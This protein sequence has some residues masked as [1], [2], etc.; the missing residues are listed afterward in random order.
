MEGGSKVRDQGRAL[1]VQPVFHEV[2][3]HRH[4]GRA[5]ERVRRVR[6]AVEKLD[7][8]FRGRVRDRVVNGSLSK[9]RPG[10]HDSPRQSLSR[11]HQ[12]WR[13]V[14]VFRSKRFAKAAEPSDHFVEN[15][16]NVVLV[17]DAADLLQVPF[18]R[19][20]HTRAPRHR[21]YNDGCNVVCPVQRHDVVEVVC[22]VRAPLWLPSGE[23]RVFEGVRVAQV[24][25]SGQERGTESS[26]VGCDPTYRNPSKPYPVV[27]SFAP[28]KARPLPLSL[29]S[30]VRERHL[31]RRVHACASTHGEE[32]LAEPALLQVAV[33]GQGFPPLE[34][35]FVSNLKSWGI[36]HRIHLFL[37]SIDHRL[38]VHA[39]STAP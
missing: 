35:Q 38:W 25:N 30:V 9:D 4:P 12:V 8:V 37:D 36:R 15:E 31:Q 21:L 24:V 11:G 33:V 3:Q 16:E 22:E 29:A 26:P 32:G 19:H 7:A 2:L 1:L 10:R 18:W 13:H 34:S 6:V 28:N 23:R 39:S 14:K 20:E 17:A 27:P 5:R